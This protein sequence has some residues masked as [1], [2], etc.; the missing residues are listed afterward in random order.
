[1]LFGSV[2]AQAEVE[3]GPHLEEEDSLGIG[4]IGMVERGWAHRHCHLVLEGNGVMLVPKDRS[5]RV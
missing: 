3:I 5:C 4:R 2:E 1:M